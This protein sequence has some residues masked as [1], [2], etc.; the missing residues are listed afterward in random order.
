MG[1]EKTSQAVKEQEVRVHIGDWA[2]WE[3]IKRDQVFRGEWPGWTSGV[4]D[5]VVHVSK[6]EDSKLEKS[7]T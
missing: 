2:S 6:A 5:T 7:K 3:S 4:Q 1:K